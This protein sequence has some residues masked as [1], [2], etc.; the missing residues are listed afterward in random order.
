MAGEIFLDKIISYGKIYV[1]YIMIAALSAAVAQ[2]AEHFLGKEEV[3]GSIPI[4]SSVDKPRNHA[5]ARHCFFGGTRKN[6][7]IIRE[8]P[9]SSVINKESRRI[10]WQRKN[11]NVKN[12]T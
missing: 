8:F 12:R 2:P 9:R 4:S 5:E 11:L 3:M 7:E 1:S 6:A 10:V